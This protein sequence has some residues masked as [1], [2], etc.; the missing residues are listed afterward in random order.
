MNLELLTSEK[1]S[2]MHNRSFGRALMADSIVYLQKGAV[3][4]DR[5]V[6]YPSPNNIVSFTAYSTAKPA[7]DSN[8]VSITALKGLLTKSSGGSYFRR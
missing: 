1:G 5:T 6:L 2:F 8:G 3:G 7:P 4:S